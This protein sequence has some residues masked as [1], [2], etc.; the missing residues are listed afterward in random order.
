MRFAFALAACVLA[1][2]TG[3]TSNSATTKTPPPTPLPPV[4]NAGGPYT[5]S[6]GTAISFNGTASTDPQGQALTYAWNFGDNTTGTGVTSN[7]TYTAAGTYTVS[8]TAT[9]TSNLTGTATAKVT[10][11]AALQPPVANAGG[12]YTGSVGT[13]IGFNGTASSDPQ[14]QALTYVWNFGDNTNG[15]GARPSHTYTSAGAFSVTLTVTDTSS[16]SG[17]A[18]TSAT[19]TAVLQSI[20]VTPSNPSVP[21]GKT[22]QFIAS[23]KYSDGSTK[24]ISSSV[25]WSS[26]LTSVATIG[27]SGLATGIK[28]GASVITATLGS[29]S[30]S[31]TLTV[32]GPT[33]QSIAVTPGGVS[34]PAGVTQAFTS[35]GTYSDGT[36]R[37]IANLVTWSSGTMSVATIAGS[38]VATGVTKGSSL[39]TATAGSVS[40][41]TTLVVT[42]ATLQSIA[43]TP[44]DP[45]FPAD[46]K[47]QFTATGS[48]SDG[49]VD[50]ITSSVTWSSATTST[51]TI[52]ATGLATGLVTGTSVISAAMGGLS[53]SSTLTVSPATLQSIAVT[54]ATV[55]IPVGLAIQFTA[56]GTYSDGKIRDITS[57]VAWSSAD[58]SVASIGTDGVA[59]SIVAGSSTIT[60]AL[61]KVSGDADLTVTPATLESIAVTPVSPSIPANSTIQLIATG[62]YSDT[63][64]QNITSLVTW[65]SGTTSVA[66]VDDSGLVSSLAVDTSVITA[67]WGNISG[68]STVT[69]TPAVA[70]APPLGQTWAVICYPQTGPGG[71]GTSCAGTS[72]PPTVSGNETGYNLPGS[73]SVGSGEGDF[74]TG[75]TSLTGSSGPYTYVY[76]QAGSSP[77][78]A[79][80][81]FAQGYQQYYFQ[82]SSQTASTATVVVNATTSLGGPM[83]GG[84][85]AVVG[86]N[87]PGGAASLTCSIELQSNNC[88]AVDPT[89]NVFAQWVNKPISVPT[90]TPIIVYTE[91]NNLAAGAADLSEPNFTQTWALANLYIELDPTFLSNN[92][93]AQLTFSPGVNQA[94]PSTLPIAGHP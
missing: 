48:Y 53:G 56:A 59:D 16:L 10:V 50:D 13:T 61:E 92:P 76:A 5:G 85:S 43:V 94:G 74:A 58:T 47:I 64:T 82:V 67:T 57:S 73:Y 21:A 17:T 15:T 35:M 88:A 7:H 39:I 11:T 90:N 72:P 63:T 55:S 42:P 62:T 44:F 51:S 23:G 71:P 29:I 37:N 80:D 31:T 14:G 54:P 22:T 24:D 66:T 38:G 79:D 26:G 46:V 8:L 69:V 70:L 41:S 75:I 65:S 60:A 77:T 18:T 89:C 20:A 45:S 52:T 49:T 91:A 83:K 40:G 68:N 32:T 81:M 3:C 34:I 78:N 6:V 4:A 25:S 27:G 36:T 2:L 1:T 93:D 12:P 9:D 28:A 86:F 84:V 33:L 87:C 19:L 30:G